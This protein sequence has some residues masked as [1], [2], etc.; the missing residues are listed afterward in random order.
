MKIN[1]ETLNEACIGCARLEIETVT[2]YASNQVY[3]RRF[4]CKHLSDCKNVK[5]IIEN[6]LELRKNEKNND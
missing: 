6:F 3:K 5:I 2:S 1:V 4:V